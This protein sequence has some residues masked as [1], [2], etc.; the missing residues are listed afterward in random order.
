MNESLLCAHT[1]CMT[2][3][4]TFNPQTSHQRWVS[5]LADSA[6][7]SPPPTPRQGFME[8]PWPSSLGRVYMWYSEFS[9]PPC[10][11]ARLHRRKIG[12]QEAL[13]SK[14]LI[15]WCLKPYNQKSVSL[16]VLVKMHITTSALGR[17]QHTVWNRP[18][19]CFLSG[20]KAG[21]WP[22]TDRL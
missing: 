7:G 6:E 18:L 1:K 15:L 5:Q 20:R 17:C 10:N 12:S 8:P 21:E 14:Y 19:D 13:L 22:G 16:L 2:C 9:S 3:A 11:W 4:N